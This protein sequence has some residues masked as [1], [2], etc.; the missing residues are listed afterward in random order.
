MT[1]KREVHDILNDDDD[2]I[3]RARELRDSRQK[4]A[5]TGLSYQQVD[6]LLAE[7]EARAREAKEQQQRQQQLAETRARAA[8]RQQDTPTTDHTARTQAL[9]RAR[10]AI[11]AARQKPRAQET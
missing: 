9:A 3:T 4:L 10:A 2:L 1:T 11:K 8:A 7:R 6:Q 5:A